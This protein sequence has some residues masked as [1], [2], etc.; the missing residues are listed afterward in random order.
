[1][2]TPRSVEYQGNWRYRGVAADTCLS[3]DKWNFCRL[4]QSTSRI[5]YLSNKRIRLLLAKWNARRLAGA[6]VAYPG[7]A[8]IAPRSSFSYCLRAFGK[9]RGQEGKKM[10]SARR[11]FR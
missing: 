4:S 3:V 11:Q 7:S 8:E 6:S 9:R 10:I 1:M 5:V 2:S